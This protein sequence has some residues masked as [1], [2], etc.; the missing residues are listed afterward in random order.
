MTPDVPRTPRELREQLVLIA[1][2]FAEECTEEELLEEE[3]FSPGTLH[4]VMQRFTEFFGGAQSSLS[5][6]QLAALGAWISQAVENDHDLENAVSTC[7]LE[8]LHQIRGYRTL[9]PHLTALAKA[10]TRA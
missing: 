5:D 6:R 8:H 2:G 7:F 4:F 3:S 10:K 9:G 1:P